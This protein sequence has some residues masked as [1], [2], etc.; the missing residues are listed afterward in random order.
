M[1]ELAA[2]LRAMRAQL[3]NTL[4]AFEAEGEDREADAD[5]EA[6]HDN[7]PDCDDEPSLGSSA[8]GPIN[9]T[10]LEHDRADDEPDHDNELSIC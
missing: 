7:E 6:E 4:A 10:D 9:M 8:G 1:P 2:H 5:N 3:V